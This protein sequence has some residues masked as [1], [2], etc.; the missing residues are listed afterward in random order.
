MHTSDTV[1]LSSPFSL[2]IRMLLEAM[3]DKSQ[4][5]HTPASPSPPF[6]PLPSKPGLGQP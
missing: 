5:H 3:Y 4:C 1:F 2:G 6:P